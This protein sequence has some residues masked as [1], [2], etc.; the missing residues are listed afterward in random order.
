MT[1][2]TIGKKKRPSS[3]LVRTSLMLSSATTKRTDL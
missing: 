1:A 3:A 2:G